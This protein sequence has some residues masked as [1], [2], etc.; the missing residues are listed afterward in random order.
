MVE[1]DAVDRPR[2]HAPYADAR[3]APTPNWR[4]NSRR[5]APA[6]AAAPVM[7]PIE[8]ERQE[9]RHRVVRPAFDFERGPQTLGQSEPARAEDGEHRRGVGRAD[10]AAE[11]HPVQERD[12][13]HPR[14]R[15]AGQRRGEQDPQGREGERRPPRRADAD[16]RGAG[17]RRRRGSAPARRPDAVGKPSRRT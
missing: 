12:V 10:D 3:S 13:Q 8:A 16:Q 2:R 15:E 5:S 9:D 1:V 7:T 4:T 14:R 6:D 17:G 11:E